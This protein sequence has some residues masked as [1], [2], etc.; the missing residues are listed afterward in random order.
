M[1][2]IS[3]IIVTLIRVITILGIQKKS[4]LENC[5]NTNYEICTMHTHPIGHKRLKTT[6]NGQSITGNIR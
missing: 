3:P 4:S 6:S 1:V 2:Q 5:S